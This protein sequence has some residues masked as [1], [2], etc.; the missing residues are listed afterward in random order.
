ML[1]HHPLAAEI[2]LAEVLH[3]LADPA[4]LAFVR[5]L[6]EE[7]GGINCADTMVKAGLPMPKS[8]CSH[9]FQVLRRAGVVFSQRRGV[10]LINFLRMDDLEARFPGLLTTI[11]AARKTEC[12]ALLAA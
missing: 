6:T 12:E 10:E 3:A 7:S 11:L 4:R 5:V 8:T 1:L 2:R 9:H